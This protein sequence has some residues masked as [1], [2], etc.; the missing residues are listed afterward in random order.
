MILHVLFYAPVAYS[1]Q[2]L[3]V[4][5]IHLLDVIIVFGFPLQNY[6]NEISGSAK[7]LLECACHQQIMD[8]ALPISLGAAVILLHNHMFGQNLDLRPCSF[9]TDVASSCS[10]ICCTCHDVNGGV[11]GI[12]LV[13]NSLEVCKSLRQYEIDTCSRI[14]A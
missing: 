1:L 7:R 9:L 6:G 12:G 3:K 2:I 13:Y 10:R 8:A 11:G 14:W 4:T 5:N